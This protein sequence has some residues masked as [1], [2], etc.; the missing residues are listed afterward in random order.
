MQ[1]PVNEP[2]NELSSMPFKRGKVKDI[3]ELD[4]EELLF[5]F[6]DRVS[7][8]DVILPSTIPRKGEVLCKLAAYWFNY[9]KVPHHMVRVEKANRMVVRKLKMIPVECV[10]RGY[11]YGSLYERLVKGEVNLPVK[12]ISAAKLPEPYFDPTTKSDV[13]DEPVTVDQIVDEGWL[14]TEE[15]TALKDS[16]LNVYKKMSERADK[17][18]FILADLK[19]EFGFDDESNIVLA[20]SIGPDEFRLWP[21]ENYSP[22]KNQE[23]YDKQLI[24]DWLS[25]VGYKKML[26]EARKAGQPTP[27]PPDLPEGLTD[28]TSKRYVIAYERLTGL[29][30]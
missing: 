10:V 15:I 11:L 5:V 7:A 3:Y 8:Y 20:D 17:A 19:L 22:G 1:E 29:K 25:K 12:P 18:G 4:S 21:K 6:T 2:E 14:D 13:K 30:L 28:E 24:R 27:R 26:D 23:S 9:L 16:S